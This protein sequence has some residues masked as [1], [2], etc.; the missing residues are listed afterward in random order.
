MP[1]R[2]NQRGGT[3]KLKDSETHTVNWR[4]AFT[5]FMR[6]SKIS[7]LTT[8]SAYGTVCVLEWDSPDGFNSP[9]IDD[10]SGATVK[11][12]IIKLNTNYETKSQ[13]KTSSKATL[14]EL[15]CRLQKILYPKKNSFM[16][17]TVEEY[18]MQAKIHRLGNIVPA[19][20]FG[21]IYRENIHNDL[22]R[23]L[24]T[25]ADKR[26]AGLIDQL[27]YFS[28]INTQLKVGIIGMEM[29]GDKDLK[30]VLRGR[31]RRARFIINKG[32]FLLIM[33]LAL[34]F[35]HGDVHAENIRYDSKMNI[36]K[37]IDLGSTIDMYENN[38]HHQQ[39]YINIRSIVERIFSSTG[40]RITSIEEFLD[41]Y[42]ELFNV[43]KDNKQEIFSVIEQL[44]KLTVS[45]PHP[46]PDLQVF[47]NYNNKDRWSAHYR[48]GYDWVVPELPENS[49]WKLRDTD[50][51]DMFKIAVEMKEKKH[52]WIPTGTGTPLPFSTVETSRGLSKRNT[53]RKCRYNVVLPPRLLQNIPEGSSVSQ[54]PQPSRCD[55]DIGN[56]LASGTR[57]ISNRQL[58]KPHSSST[59][60]IRKKK[61]TSKTRKSRGS[62]QEET[63]SNSS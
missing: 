36:V 20:L 58:Y 45:K 14:S 10:T 22:L 39:H 16:Q 18:N 33:L 40:C 55:V 23:L 13:R 59:V 12:I 8:S 27:Q 21:G 41:R 1:R 51:K 31:M 53:T 56:I 62:S 47:F 61:S 43:N 24:R 57:R 11:K 26:S 15:D 38:T 28:N 7:F 34:G 6:N 29:F 5:H 17:D 42:I 35:L 46:N 32:R 19:L 30:M 25:S 49:R 2:N 4:T 48:E 52:H 37:F 54:C 9:Y 50:I 60:K 3:I 63:K 44:L